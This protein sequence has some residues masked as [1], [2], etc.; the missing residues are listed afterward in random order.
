MIIGRLRSLRRSKG[1]CREKKSWVEGTLFHSDRKRGKRTGVILV[2]GPL[3][4]ET[5]SGTHQLRGKEMGRLRTR[6]SPCTVADHQEMSRTSTVSVLGRLLGLGTRSRG[7]YS[8][9]AF[10]FSVKQ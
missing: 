8:L 6:G 7:D 1:I 4:R 5:V 3:T 9:S 10:M 2:Y